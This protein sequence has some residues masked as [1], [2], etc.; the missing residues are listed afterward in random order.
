MRPL[1]A[2]EPERAR[3]VDD[4]GVDGDQ[5]EVGTLL[6]G[7]EARLDGGGGGAVGGLGDGLAGDVEVGLGDGVVAGP[8]LELD[9]AAGGGSDL[10]GP[11]LVGC[12]V[13]DGVPANKDDMDIN[14]CERVSC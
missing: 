4:D 9:D 2:E 10:L 8:E 3:V 5:A 13:V 12:D 6:D 14:S 7:H 1:S 11:V